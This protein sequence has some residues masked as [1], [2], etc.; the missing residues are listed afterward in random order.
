MDHTPDNASSLRREL[1]ETRAR[2][3]EAEQTLNAI[4]TGEVDGLVVNGAAGPQV[5]TL[6]SSE[7][8]YRM[9]IERMSE[10]ALTLSPE[11]IILYSNQTFARL[12]QVPLEQ[13]IGTDLRAFL[14]PANDAD[15]AG[16]IAAAWEGSNRVEISVR[17]AN[18]SSIPVRLGLSRLQS[19]PQRLLC[20]VATDL[21]EERKLEETTRR[22]QE[23]LEKRVAERT[24][25]LAAAR[26]AALNMMEDAV[27]SRKALEAANQ[28]LE[29]E[30]VDRKL[31]EAEVRLINTGLEK[32]VNERTA[33]V[34]NANQILTQRTDELEAAMKELDSFAYSVSHDLRAPLR[35]IGGFTGLL[36]KSAGAGLADKS[37]QYLDQITGATTQMGQLIDDLLLFSRMSRTGLQLRPLDLADLVEESIQHLQP[38]TN[39]RNIL[40][41]KHPLPAVRADP[42]LLR[43]ALINLLANAIKYTRPRDP[44]KIEIGC[45]GED[46]RE[47]VIYIRDNGVGFDM[48]Y[49]DK[50]FHVFQ[51][52]HAD[53][54][55]EG[56]GIGL[57]NV[58]RVIARHGGRTWAEGKLGE[59]ATFYFS[60]P[61]HAPGANPDNSNTTAAEGG[62]RTP[63]L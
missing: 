6:R 61:A 28:D 23:D 47:H 34:R 19:A 39:G 3:L 51:R 43:Q 24:A 9:L 54:D 49:A 42:A 32:R 38:E 60:L 59:G 27:E 14:S 22:L 8:P 26:V 50:L 44:A 37:R 5:F 45:S 40:W 17:A 48:R 46:S 53:E 56:T 13:I 30:I 7:E 11:G 62:L 15:L 20:V 35:H 41:T 21:T 29:H 18:G 10:G 2:L 57:A 36:R 31:A 4:R 12:L 58:R 55:F 33:Q 1:E 63:D 52:L 25:D 16:I